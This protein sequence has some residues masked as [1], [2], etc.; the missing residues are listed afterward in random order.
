[1]KLRQ[2]RVRMLQPVRVPLPL[3]GGELAFDRGQV[4]LVD[5]RLAELWIRRGIAEAVTS[6]DDLRAAVAGQPARRF[7]E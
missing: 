4:A 3:T 5:P 1:M 6:L 7:S 2:R